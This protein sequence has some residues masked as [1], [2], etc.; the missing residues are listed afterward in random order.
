ML[1]INENNQKVVRVINLDSDSVTETPI[2][3]EI[4]NDNL[5]AMITIGAK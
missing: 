1:A 4:T 3:E 5:G 2:P